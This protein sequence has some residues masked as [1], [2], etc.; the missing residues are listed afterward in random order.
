MQVGAV[1]ETV[2]VSSAA[3][4]I[5]VSQS[6]VQTNIP[7]TVLMN[8]PTQTRSFQSV[9][10]LAPGARTEPL[11]VGYQ[12]DGAS[13]SENAYLVEGLDTG[14]LLG[15]DSG[16]NFLM[17][18]I[19]EVQVKTSGFEAEYGGALGGVVNVIQRRGSNQWHGSV[20]TYY[21]GDKF[22]AA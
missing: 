17:D 8:V 21:N 20:F 15:G 19:Q 9:I 1:A 6:K 4:L 5:D 10:Q 13:N 18:F 22:D 14:S 3:A 7:D 11:Q 12:I 16:A 2:E